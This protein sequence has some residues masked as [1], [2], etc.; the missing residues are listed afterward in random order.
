MERRTAEAPRLR[1]S[2]KADWILLGA[3]LAACA[4]LILV[5]RAVGEGRRVKAEI[6]YGS[7]LAETVALDTGEERRFSIP[8]NEH[9]VFHLYK[10]GSIAFEESDCPDKV[11]IRAG[12]LSR[13]GQ[14]AACLPNKITLKIV[15]D[16]RRDSDMDMAVR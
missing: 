7:E 14:S 6:Y 13:V 11:C 2:R 15:A 16:G 3:V 12:K 1:F 4:A 5:F 8:Q 9:V 10:D